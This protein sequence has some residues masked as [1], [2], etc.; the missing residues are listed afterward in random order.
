[1]R[2]LKKCVSLLAAAALATAALSVTGPAVAT[3]ICSQQEVQR[4]SVGPGGD[5]QAQLNTAKVVAHTRLD[6]AAPIVGVLYKSFGT[7][8][9]TP[10]QELFSG[11]HA[12]VPAH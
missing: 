1:M 3:G 10:P 9:Q 2:S 7:T 5:I 11:G 12:I 4:L 8:G 6:C